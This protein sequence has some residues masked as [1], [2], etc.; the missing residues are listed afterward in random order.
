MI[1]SFRDFSKLLE[2]D[3][4]YNRTANDKKVFKLNVKSTFLRLSRQWRTTKKL[5]TV[6]GGLTAE[7]I[8]PCRSFNHLDMSKL[9]DHHR[10]SSMSQLASYHVKLSR[11]MVA[12]SASTFKE[13]FST[14]MDRSRK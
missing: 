2:Y 7:K 6:K 10:F 3:Y 5:W 1:R 4:R 8:S 9:V 14:S 11:T 13:H 12:A